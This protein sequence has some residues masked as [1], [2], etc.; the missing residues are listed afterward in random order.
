MIF[1]FK[2]K[3]KTSRLQNK[4]TRSQPIEEL[5]VILGKSFDFGIDII[6]LLIHYSYF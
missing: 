3:I 6:R 1:R 4:A 5:L 2:S